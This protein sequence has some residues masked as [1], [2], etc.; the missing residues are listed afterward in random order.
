MI[1]EAAAAPGLF[2]QQPG[3]ISSMGG[4]V[5]PTSSQTPFSGF[6][7]GTA[8]K[9]GYGSSVSGSGDKFPS[10]LP[11]AIQV[12]A[13]TIGFDLVGVVPMDAPVGFLPYLDY[14]Y[15][16][17][18][19]DKQYEPFLVKLTGAVLAGAAGTGL[20]ASVA[21]GTVYAIDG[22]LT[23]DLIVQYVGRSRVDGE[24]I[25]K[26]ISATD[27]SNS[28]QDYLT[29]GS[30]VLKAVSAISSGA[31]AATGSALFTFSKSEKFELVSALENHIS[32]FTSLSDDKWTGTGSTEASDVTG[33]FM[34]STGLEMEGMTRSESEASRFRQMGL[35]MFTKFIEA[36][37]DQIAISATVE[38]IQDLNRVWNFDVISM[39]E[40]VAVNELAQSIN[41]KIVDR[42]LALG[43]NHAAAIDFCSIAPAHAS[44]TDVLAEW[45]RQ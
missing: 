14:V 12:A 10:L 6:G 4:I 38:Q 28:I 8:T 27:A 18:N 11:V 44:T 30:P 25:F 21:A 31:Y 42:V 22:A 39:L 20:I 15:Q 13:K 36:K 34:G 32:G 2:L 37:G 29:T 1:N 33:P 7:T 26:V 5:A 43:K 23:D 45:W 35:R 24:P 16:G 17:G 19:V 40:N 41:K 9:A 3:S